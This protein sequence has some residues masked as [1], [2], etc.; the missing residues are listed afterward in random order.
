MHK[1]AAVLLGAALSAAIP[2][3]AGISVIPLPEILT[4]PNEGNTYGFL[5]VVLLLDPQ[6]RIEHIIASDVRYNEI[7]GVYPAF[8]LFGYP[9]IDLKYY[10]TLRKSQNIDEDYIGEYEHRNLFG[11]LVDVLSNVTFFRDSRLR[12]YGFGNDTDDETETNYTQ[13]KF[14]FLLRLAYRFLPEWQIAWQARVEDVG[15]ADGGVDKLPFTAE[16]FPMTKGLEG[17]RIH[18][19]RVI[20]AYDDRDSPTITTRGTY[21]AGYFEL[22]DEALGSSTSFVK[23]G[24]EVREFVPLHERVVLALHG[25][26]DYTGG[27]DR[28]PF[29][30]LNSIGGKKS[31]RGFGTDRFVDAHRFFSSVELRT[32]AFRRELFGVVPELEVAPFADVGQ[33]FSDAASVPFDDL[34]PVAGVGF[35]GVVRPQVVGFVDLGFGTD[36][37]AVFTGLDYPF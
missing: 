23:Y 5:P 12:F 9:T 6:G 8:R 18:G 16:L 35:R 17:S 11:G 4:D 29:Y 27:A 24:F 14:S 26:L 28:A 21:G 3:L 30:E 15:I 10:L 31:L 2:A 13:R 20:F 37:P 7:T 19:E 34:H 32:M 22:V 25:V 1:L 36:G 33:V